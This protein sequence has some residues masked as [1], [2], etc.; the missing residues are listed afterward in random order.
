VTFLYAVSTAT[1]SQSTFAPAIGTYTNT[2]PA[3]NGADVSLIASYCGTGADG[4]VTIA[5]SKNINTDIIGAGRT[6]ADG[7]S[8]RVS[9]LT[10]NTATL[11]T[12][13]PANTFA[14]GDEALLISL[15][16]GSST[17]V[18]VG[19]YEFLRVASVA[20]AVV[21]F[22]ANKTKYYGDADG[23]DVNVGVSQVVMLQR[24]PNYTNVTVNSGGTITCDNWDGVA[25]G[26]V[27]AFRAN[28]TVQVNVANGI[29]VT[30]KGFG[31]GGGAANENSSATGG[32]SYN[33]QGGF[34]GNQN[35]NGFTGQ[36]GGGGG[37]SYY[38]TF[39]TGA[40]G[41]VGSGGGG[42]G[43]G[44]DASEQSGGGG[45]GGNG[46]VG[47]AGPS[48]ITPASP[49]FVSSGGSGAN[50][51]KYSS[52]GVGGGGGGGGNDG[53]S[54]S[55]TLD[56]RAYL[57][58]GGGGSGGTE[59]SIPGKAGGRGGGLIF[60]GLNTLNVVGGA[61]ITADG[62]AGTNS[63]GAPGGGGGGAGG[64][65][66][67]MGAQITNSG[68]IIANGGAGGS[69]PNSGGTGGGGRTYAQYNSLS[70][71]NPTPNY[72]GVQT[73]PSYNTGS[74]L[75]LLINPDSGVAKW[76]TLLWN[77]SIPVSTTLTVDVLNGSD[78]SLL[79]Q[80]VVSGTDL[81]TLPEFQNYTGSIKLRA[82]LST[83][84]LGITPLLQD[85]SVS[86]ETGSVR[87]YSSTKSGQWTDSTVWNPTGIPQQGDTVTIGS[88][89]QIT[90]QDTR[91]VR[92]L[93]INS[94]GTLA[95]NRTASE[96]PILIIDDTGVITN[97]GTV[98]A[99]G[100]TS[101]YPAVVS[102]TGLATITNNNALIT[103]TNTGQFWQFSNLVY[104]PQLYIY[105]NYVTLIGNF[106]ADNSSNDIVV[107]GA[108]SSR[109]TVADNGYLRCRAGI[110]SNRYLI[111]GKNTKIE[112]D[113]Q[114]VGLAQIRS[115]DN[116]VITATGTSSASRDCR[117]YRSSTSV[118]GGRY[119]IYLVN[120]SDSK[121]QYCD[122]AGMERVYS[123]QVAGAATGTIAGEGLTIDSCNI[124]D[125]YTDQTASYGAY[126]YYS[127]AGSSQTG[128]TI[129][130]SNIYNIN[131]GSTTNYGI[132][133]QG[134]VANYAS[135][136]TITNNNIYN[137]TTGSSQ[138][139]G[140]YWEYN[141]DW[142]AP[143]TFNNNAI[144]NCGRGI[145][146]YTGKNVTVSNCNFGTL[147]ANSVA[148]ISFVSGVA[149]RIVLRNCLLG[150]PTE[151]EYSTITSSQNYVKSLRHD[152]T[153]GLIRLWGEYLQIPTA[154]ES[155]RYDS[156]LYSGSGDAGV[157]KIIEFGPS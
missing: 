26:G 130:N 77:G 35:Q 117:I 151:V 81:S 140:V 93:T 119:E 38:G 122:M 98:Q 54:S 16:G 103:A 3:N 153:P 88:G 92:N 60:I 7:W 11:V 39:R 146:F 113:R 96:S 62:N 155:Y 46:G 134:G 128:N 123:D 59:G 87:T 135:G 72:L 51:G 112:M 30:G 45:G 114:T 25:K 79:A 40:S 28:G 145:R 126:L 47:S 157:Q 22:T 74:Y 127:G 2:Q 95:F 116:G 5:V 150:S 86:Y 70:G 89:H 21:T 56:Q 52:V 144:Y 83:T 99:S 110:N 82:N 75:S 6:V 49:G 13:P 118:G 124:H 76:R 71:N 137:I 18:N 84:A 133:I 12:T 97:S 69:G 55:A 80:N 105:D 29:N 78:Y 149:N 138:A 1:W 141:D 154:G 102:S 31:S 9:G 58:G 24:V 34:G 121:F 53:R 94:N 104:Q 131:G 120:D 107:V 73:N 108:G 85:W 57:G 139:N 101:A 50:G 68:S 111:F 36:G 15:K 156:E 64:S 106:Y 37:G 90:I 41:T 67:V 61:S 43:G 129:T 147:G 125:S 8:S 65:I 14:V 23:S 142:S 32:E 91:Y 63:G 20:G 33:G 42:S 109:L 152:N 17:Y 44:S 132:F 48:T 4:S 66:I 136:H 27:V 100:T 10:A 115:G 19:I 143:T 148:D